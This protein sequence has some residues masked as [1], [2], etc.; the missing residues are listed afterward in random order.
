MN[1]EMQMEWNNVMIFGRHV[2]TENTLWLTMSGSGIAFEFGPGLCAITLSG[3]DTATD[4]QRAMHRASYAIYVD[5][6]P[7]ARGIMDTR[8][9]RIEITG[10][11]DGLTKVRIVKL[12]E[13]T[14][15]LLGI[16]AIRADG[17]RPAE[18]Q[19]LKIEVIGD[20]I[21]CGYGVEGNETQTFSTA[22]ENVE[23]A[24]GSLIGRML[25]A[26]VRMD[27]FSGFG[28][29]SGYTDTGAINDVCLVPDYYE[30]VGMNDFV[31]P[32][33]RRVQDIPWRFELFQPDIVVLNLG[34]NDLSWCRDDAEKKQRF[35]SLYTEFLKTIRRNNRSAVI[36]CVLGIMGT[37]LNR[38]M[39]DAAADY[40]KGSGDCKVYTLLTDEQDGSKNGWGTD[41]HP[42]ETTQKQLASA[43][44]AEIRRLC[45]EHGIA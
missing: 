9:K 15:S 42:S 41:F 45:A 43:V 7:F 44:A 8:E 27:C 5:E 37:G 36:L 34:T 13:C 21:T 25:N 20:S 10:T 12:S 38:S 14:S 40:R 4:E 3:D 29:V 11:K 6:R 22:T 32:D 1:G 39:E 18:T 31:L 24:Y 17:I 16:S 23:K 28:I 26:D 35:R 30:K 19:R 2:V 33:G